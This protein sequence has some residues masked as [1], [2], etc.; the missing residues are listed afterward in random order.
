M[1]TCNRGHRVQLGIGDHLDKACS[2]CAEE[3]RL[4]DE[5]L[6]PGVDVHKM[7]SEAL[8]VLNE[9]GT[10]SNLIAQALKE[11]KKGGDGLLR[12]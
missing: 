4:K 7:L 3:D 12:M 10:H 11:Y 6:E 9:Q 8:I 1:I 5:L 2:A